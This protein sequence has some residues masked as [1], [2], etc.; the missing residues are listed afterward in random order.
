MKPLSHVMLGGLTGVALLLSACSGGGDTLASPALTATE[1]EPVTLH[2]PSGRVQASG[3]VIAG[4]TTRTGPW[5]TYFDDESGQRQWE[6]SYRDGVI[7][8]SKPWQ[9]WNRDGSVRFDSTDQ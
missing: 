1:V 4:T 5:I 7:D 2:Y 8:Q 6:G 9:E 3:G